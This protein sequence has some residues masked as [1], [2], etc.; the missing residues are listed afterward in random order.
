MTSFS[1]S[2]NVYKLLNKNLSFIP[3]PKLYNKKELKNDLDVFFRRIKLKAYFKDS[4]NET[5]SKKSELYFPSKTNWTPKDNHHSIETYIEAVKKDLNETIDKPYK[6]S[7]KTK[8]HNLSK[9]EIEALSYLSKRDDIIITNADKGGAVVIIDIIQYKKEAQ[10]QLNDSATY[11]LLDNNV[12]TEN[13]K[14]VINI[15]NRFKNDQLISQKTAENLKVI[16]PRTPRLYFLP[17]VHKKEIPG[18]PVVSS[19]DCPTA[20]ISKFIDHHLQPIVQ[21]IPSY[22]KDTTDF[23]NKINNIVNVHDQSIFVSLDVKSLY[24]NIP[25]SEGIAAVKRAFDN[26]SNKLVSTKVIVTFLSLILTLNNFSFNSKHYLQ[27]K[28]CAMGTSCAPAYANIF[29]ADFESKYIYPLIKNKAITY[30]RYIDDIFMIWTASMD[31]LQN[32]IQVLNSKHQSIRFEFN[33]STLKMEFLDVLLYKDQNH[34]IQTTLYKKP[35]DHQSYLHAKSEHPKSLKNSIA[36]SQTLRIRRICS[37]DS[38]FN[39][40]SKLLLNNFK[41]RG[42]HTSYIKDQIKDIKSVN[43]RELLS[44]R[45]K[46]E[47]KSRIPLSITYNKTLPNIKNIVEKYWHVLK[48]NPSF[49]KAFENT[50]I[51]AFRRNLNLKDIIGSNTIENDKVKRRPSVKTKGKCSPCLSNA[52]SLCCKQ[53]LKTEKF[54]STQNKKTFEIYH[55]VNCKSKN[56][57][58][59]ME[60]TKCKVQ[61]IGKSETN[62]NIRLNN[63]R[64]DTNNINGIPASRHF[65]KPYHEFNI[66]AKFIIIEQIKNANV[67]KE[68]I[69]KRLKA[70]E[71][72]WIQTLET[73]KPK[74]LNQEL[75]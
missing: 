34:N 44:P 68:T 12:T 69:T 74:G 20:K 27:R 31:E 67:S 64:K 26:Y 50:P 16:D 40:H 36:Y 55:H 56:I 23:L 22:I 37:T 24:T 66:H 5:N 46:E 1:F 21:K 17:K 25:N 8:S 49:E 59:L 72:F 42:Y 29:M 10:R 35:N 73:L 9:G 47:D 48:I 6:D 38:E 30:L 62:F 65:S 61:Y 45:T 7:K 54:Q 3:T 19:I 60:C 11:K 39:K 18:R 70:R 43:R 57:I 15:I 32:F 71:N 75:N 14:L 41:E 52:K 28:G 51:I 13:N 53:I 58:Y 4:P 63:H 33:I 2:K